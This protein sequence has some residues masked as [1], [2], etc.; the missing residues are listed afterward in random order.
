MKEVKRKK[1]TLNHTI[2]SNENKKDS[3][4]YNMYVFTG[5]YT[6]KKRKF[7]DCK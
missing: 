5:I 7:I 6:M 3:H 1:T 4:T 2:F